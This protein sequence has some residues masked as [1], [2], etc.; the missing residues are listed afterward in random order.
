V[1]TI[2]IIFFIGLVYYNDRRVV[3]SILFSP[4]TLHKPSSLKSAYVVTCVY[5]FST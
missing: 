5:Y 3:F 1:V 2:H 4:K